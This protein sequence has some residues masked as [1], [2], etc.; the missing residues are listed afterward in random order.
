MLD[1]SKEGGTVLACCEDVAK[2]LV[3][4]HHVSQ[5]WR[6]RCPVSRGNSQLCRKGCTTQSRSSMLKF[7]KR[8]ETDASVL[9]FEKKNDDD[10]KNVKLKINN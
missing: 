10:F 7:L 3:V 8:P 6:F 9:P 4:D 5:L 2:M 1:C